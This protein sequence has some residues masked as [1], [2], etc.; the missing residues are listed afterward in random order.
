[1]ENLPIGKILKGNSEKIQKDFADFSNIK[2]DLNI[3]ACETNI[4]DIAMGQNTIAECVEVTGKGTF[5][6]KKNRN[7]RLC[8]SNKE[9]W[10]FKRTDIPDSEPIKVDYQ[11]AWTTNYGGVN[12]IVLGLSENEN[13]FI[14]LTEHIIALKTAIGID[15]LIIETDSYDPPLFERGSLDIIEALNKAGKKVFPGKRKHYKVKEKTIIGYS[16]RGFLM[17]EPPENKKSGELILDCAINYSDNVM[18]IQ[19]ICFPVTEELFTKG[20]IARTNTSLKHAFMCKTIGKLLPSTR[21]IG[22]NIKNILIT[23]KNRYYNKPRLIEDGKVLEPIWHRAV[24]DLLAAV[25][26]IPDGLLVGKLTSYKAG[27]TQDVDF[28]KELY[29]NNMLVEI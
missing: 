15:N 24:L 26:L 29:K 25:A 10:F 22:Y 23:G 16:D 8:P 9:G 1:M 14:R 12:N 13:N 27:H 28:I 4:T 18:G 20:A 19:R 17:L 7:L 3:P 5:N 2:F 11:H 6:Y 21:N